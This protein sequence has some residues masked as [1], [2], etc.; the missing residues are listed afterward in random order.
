MH[1][2]RERRAAIFQNDDAEAFVHCLPSSS[3][4]DEVGSDSRQDKRVD[5]SFAEYR[6]E[7]G[8]GE[9]TDAPLVD[10][11]L[12]GLR[13]RVAVK[14]GAPRSG[15]HRVCLLEALEKLGAVV[16]VGMTRAERHVH[17]DHVDAF[18]PASASTCDRVGAL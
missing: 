14:L 11:E 1:R 12:L 17:V 18:P 5:L 16:D 9:W 3:L 8:T 15:D 10:R 6:A 13:F 7:L 2:F 4:D